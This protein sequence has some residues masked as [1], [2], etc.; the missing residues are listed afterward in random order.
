M[1]RRRSSGR[2]GGYHA[3]VLIPLGTDRPR[4]HSPVITLTLIGVNVFIFVALASLERSNPD[5]AKSIQY[6]GWI[7]S[8]DFHFHG[9]I[10]SAFLHANWSHILFNML[11]L[12]IFGPNIEDKLGKIGFS[13]FYVLAAVA[14]ASL[15]VLFS[16]HPAIGASGAIAGVTGAYL[17]LFPRTTIRCLFFF[18]LIGIVSIPAWWFI[19][20]SISSDFLLPAIRGGSDGIAHLAHIGGYLFGFTVSLVLLWTKVL[21]REPYDLFTTMRQ[22][23]R[24]ADLRS[25][26]EWSQRDQDKARNKIER[27]PVAAAK[28]EARAAVSA[29]ISNDDLAGAEIAFELLLAE[30]G[31]EA[32]LLSRQRHYELANHLFQSGNHQTAA[33]AYERFIHGYPNDR[34]LAHTKLMLGL[35]SARYLND[36]IR[37]ERLIREAMGDGLGPEE[38]GIAQQILDDLGANS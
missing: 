32:A 26:H 33:I 1:L 7:W 25:A 16:E 21:A 17:V 24:R 4:K 18:F 20:F 2:L 35:I 9:L 5:Q 30:H 15:H 23:K 12:W 8:R 3:R 19:A 10:T 36:P 11:F 14:S 38:Q 31:A 22:A 37:G 27:D 13:F 34:E 6:W 28:A 29:A